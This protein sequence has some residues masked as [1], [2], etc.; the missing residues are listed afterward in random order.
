[1]RSAIK[2][3]DQVDFLHRGWE[4]EVVGVERVMQLGWWADALLISQ[5]FINH[6]LPPWVDAFSTQ[7]KEIKRLKKSVSQFKLR[8]FLIPVQSYC[9]IHCAEDFPLLLTFCIKSKKKWDISFNISVGTHFFQFQKIFFFTF[10]Q[11]F[12]KDASHRLDSWSEGTGSGKE[13]AAHFS[14]TKG[15]PLLVTGAAPWLAEPG[16]GLPPLHQSEGAKEAGQP[17]LHLGPGQRTGSRKQRQSAP[18]S[19]FLDFTFLIH[20]WPITRVDF[21]RQICVH[22][23]WCAPPSKKIYLLLGRS[24]QIN[25]LVEVDN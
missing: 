13:A 19:W 2:E 15:F 24:R 6:P 12:Q 14:G 7:K 21:F 1:M 17:T 3:S 4:C 22:L 9:V 8:K 18:R 11:F 10:N 20:L 23:C 25:K 16:K 5:V